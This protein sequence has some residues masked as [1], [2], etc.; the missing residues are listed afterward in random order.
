LKFGT[1]KNGSTDDSTRLQAYFNA[2]SARATAESAS[3]RAKA[4]LPPGRYAVA[5]GIYVPA[6]VDL[7]MSGA[8]LI[9]TGSDYDEPVLTIGE[10]NVSCN[11]G[12]YI[13]L[14]VQ[15]PNSN[16]RYP[17]AGDDLWAAIR[18]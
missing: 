4:V 16:H 14:S 6:N 18:V 13:G 7:D 15:A 1:V 11:H 17:V 5:S 9:Y 3:A 10:E 2:L 8:T 12:R